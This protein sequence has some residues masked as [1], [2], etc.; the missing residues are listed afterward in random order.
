MALTLTEV[1]VMPGTGSKRMAIWEITGDGE[2][3]SFNV[4]E[5]KMQKVEA[6]WVENLDNPYEL[7]LA[8]YSGTDTL[9]FEAGAF[10]EDGK[11]HLLFVIGY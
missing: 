9:A 6:A 8:T 2:S 1:M 7:K 3:Y 4:I 11:K 10:L 5:L